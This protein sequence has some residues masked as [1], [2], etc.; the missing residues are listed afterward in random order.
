METDWKKEVH[1]LFALPKRAKEA[2]ELL[3]A[4]LTPKE[5][6]E[7]ARRWHIVSMLLEGHPQREVRDR[8]RVS[9]A[10]VTRGAREIQYGNG[11]F[12]K[13]YRRLSNTR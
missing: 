5:Y 12:Q 9:I 4:I 2:R 11:V 13:Y 6:D 7:I 3:E 8:A 10:T 1:R